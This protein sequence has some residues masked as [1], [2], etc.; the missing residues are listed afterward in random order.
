MLQKPLSMKWN[1][2]HMGNYKKRQ[3]YGANL[4]TFSL[5]IDEDNIALYGLIGKTR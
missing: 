1:I 2:L 5:Y 4:K 3:K